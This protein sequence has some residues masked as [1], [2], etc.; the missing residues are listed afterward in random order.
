MAELQKDPGYQAFLEESER[1]T[2]FNRENYR[3]EAAP[4][5]A[6]L[7]EADFDVESVGELV[8]RQREYRAAVPVLLRWLPKISDRRVRE[9]IIRTL[10]VP[11]AR[12]DAVRPLI[13]EFRKLRHPDENGI[14][15]VI[16]N[17]LEVIAD[18]AIFE[19]VVAIA[20]DKRYGSS[21]EMVVAALGN[22]K[23]PKAKE[24]LIVLDDDDVAGYA[25]MGLGKLKAKEAKAKIEP[26]LNHSQQW[27]RQEAR[28]ALRKM[29]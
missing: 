27:V 5:L 16:G 3:R 6:D 2:Q 20:T 22:M 17:A 28:K 7:R 25:I 21:R 12:P 24:V 14:G 10:S 4:V 11:W 19:D 23:N 29:G 13:A 15:W 9:D 26:F 1:R 18:D 8:H